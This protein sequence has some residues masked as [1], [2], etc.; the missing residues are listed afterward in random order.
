MPTKRVY[1]LPTEVRVTIHDM[2]MHEKLV[3]LYLYNALYEFE[4][5]KFIFIHAIQPLLILF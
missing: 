4:I 1:E 2:L 5:S 3:D